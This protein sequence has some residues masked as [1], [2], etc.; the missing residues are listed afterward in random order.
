MSTNTTT[1][2]ANALIQEQV[3]SFLVEPLEAES[4]VLAAKPKILNSSEPLLIPRL[5]SVGAP[6]WV[7]ENEL[8]PES[9]IAFSEM[10]LMP[11]ER[12]S[13]KV[14][15]RASNESIRLAKQGVS[16]ILQQALVKRV[17]NT[18]DD[19]LLKGKGEDATVTGILNQA[20]VQTGTLDVAAPD[21]L[22]EII[23][24]A[25][26]EEVTPNR[27]F[28]SAADYLS[29]AKLKDGNERYLLQNSK[30]IDGAMVKTLFDIPVTV[31]NKLKAGEGALVD[32]NEIAVV[33]DIDPKITVDDSRYLEY[34]QVAIRI[35][36]RYDLGL[37]H[38][39]GV[40]VFGAGE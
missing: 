23:A 13:I 1:T 36:T 40:V 26:A 6:A 15:H 27:W 21:S 33:R 31:T 16:T 19:A 8:I 14:M 9:D 34:D 18:L 5:D 30:A 32:M 7:G 24:K 28:M 17:S 4:V 39:K 37:L 2:T 3:A 10:K 12:K 38:P 20:G 35:V 22:L 11:T 29:L 25:E